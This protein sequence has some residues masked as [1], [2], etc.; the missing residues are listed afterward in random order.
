VLSPCPSFDPGYDPNDNSLVLHISYAGRSLLFA[1]DI[2]AYAEDRLVRSQELRADVLKVAH[3]GSRTSSSEAF[4]RA[5]RPAIAIVSAGAANA[6]GHPH[7]EV[8]ERLRRLVPQVID[9][10]ERG[11]TIVDVA[12]S[13]ELHVQSS[14]P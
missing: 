10:G 14:E 2:E 12:A 6:F 9:L 5:V 4:I 11:G 7:A 13:G 1:G 8:M 3:H